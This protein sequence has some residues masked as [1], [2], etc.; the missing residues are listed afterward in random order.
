MDTTS[1]LPVLEAQGPSAAPA[2][3]RL[4]RLAA[5]ARRRAGWIAAAV[6]LA[7]ALAG[8]LYL[9]TWPP[10]AVVESGSMTPTIHT[11]DVVLLAHLDRPPRDGDIVA[12]QVPYA[13]RARFGYPPEVVHRVIQVLPNGDLHTK[14]DALKTPD[15]FTTA[16]GTVNAHVVATIPA[17][18][19]VVAFLTS[20]L[21]L[22]WLAAGGVM[23]IV[24]PLLDRRRQRDEQ[25]RESVAAIHAKLEELS[26][27]LA[28][29]RD[30]DAHA[31]AAREQLDFLAVKSD[32]LERQ[33]EEAL[34]RTG[35]E[36][37]AQIATTSA[38]LA[39]T[40]ETLRAPQ[41]PGARAWSLRAPDWEGSCPR[42][43]TVGRRS[44]P[45]S[46]PFWNEDFGD[47]FAPPA[48]ASETG[49]PAEHVIAPAPTVADG[50]A[51]A[52]QSAL[53]AP[54][55]VGGYP[56]GHIRTEARRRS[57]GLL[58]SVERRARTAHSRWRG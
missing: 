12:V 7:A 26:A 50:P 8:L 27:E 20:T 40:L 35:D 28:R 39:S 49:L 22:I 54:L 18:G 58:G 3:H 16:R 5:S 51:P 57:G 34:A 41:P 45:L 2:A 46:S 48:S 33:F 56:V 11:G 14:G 6:A 31:A 23:L 19:R 38:G 32:A 55:A 10:L 53:A 43:S 42:L 21:G 52:V 17:A 1:V 29:T 4:R 47:A 25:E 13:A 37:R 24:L 36:L 15:P 30:D 9:H 44:G